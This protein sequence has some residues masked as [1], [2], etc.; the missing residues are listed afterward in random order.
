MFGR[1][2]IQP[3]T[4]DIAGF[5]YCECVGP[6]LSQLPGTTRNGASGCGLHARGA[7]GPMPGHDRLEQKHHKFLMV[8]TY[9]ALRQGCRSHRGANETR[10]EEEPDR[11]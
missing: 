11:L 5:L 7:T 9:L 3:A 2:T 1:A 6:H 8:D 4:E 10:A